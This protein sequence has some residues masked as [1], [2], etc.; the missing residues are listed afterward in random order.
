MP[1]DPAGIP[2]HR[3]P[4]GTDPRRDLAR[5]CHAV[6]WLQ[7]FL[8]TGD[9]TL[10]GGSLMMLETLRDAGRRATALL[11]HPPWLWMRCGEAAGAAAPGWLPLGSCSRCRR[12]LL[13]LRE[14]CQPALAF[15]ILSGVDGKPIKI[16]FLTQTGVVVSA[17]LR[18]LNF[19][20]PQNNQPFRGCVRNPGG[21]RSRQKAL[22]D[23]CA[24]LPVPLSRGSCT[25]SPM[26]APPGPQPLALELT[27]DFQRRGAGGKH[28][29]N[30]S[31]GRRRRA[32]KSASSSQLYARPALPMPG[33]GR[34][35]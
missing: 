15:P 5:G 14:L 22:P 23:A 10:R 27:P 16:R 34:G 33:A 11:L 6:S 32:G 18:R 24:R 25:G 13:A 9:Q 28:C 8:R 20:D 3:S 30:S 29:K 35:C 21:G 26:P 31:R 19:T 12:G 17:P 4:L 2:R 1:V 7:R